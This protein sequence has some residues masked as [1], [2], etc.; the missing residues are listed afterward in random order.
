M[1]YVIIILILVYVLPKLI[2]KP[3]A[4]SSKNP[5]KIITSD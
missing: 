3:K 5:I 1:K 4:K 2:N